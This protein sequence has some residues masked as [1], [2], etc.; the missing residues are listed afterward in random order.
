MKNHQLKSSVHYGESEDK[1]KSFID[2]WNKRIEKRSM[3]FHLGRRVEMAEFLLL[4][5]MGIQAFIVNRV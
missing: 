4:D 2:S 5:I 1:N 3:R